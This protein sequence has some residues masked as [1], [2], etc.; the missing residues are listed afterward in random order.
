METE[1]V[2]GYIRT[3]VFDQAE[4]KLYRQKLEIMDHC[5]K[6]NL[7]LVKVFVDNG[8]TGS[9]LQRKGWHDLKTYLNDNRG[10]VKS[11]IVPDYSRIARDIPKALAEISF[12]KTHFDLGTA[13]AKEPVVLK[14]SV[15]ALKE[16][17]V[18]K[19]KKRK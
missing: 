17:L 4:E 6:N 18:P 19:W 3:A 8:V 14:N 10:K 15:K 9:T 13:L 5:K 16:I 2:I 7:N 12:L 11:L 1:N